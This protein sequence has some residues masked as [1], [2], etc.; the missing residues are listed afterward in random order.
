[1]TDWVYEGRNFKAFSNE[2]ICK[3]L[4]VAKHFFKEGRNSMAFFKVA[5]LKISS[6]LF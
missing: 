5:F 3:F 4:K 2:K 1:M 6:N